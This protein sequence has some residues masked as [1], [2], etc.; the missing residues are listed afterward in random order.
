MDDDQSILKN[1]DERA[2]TSSRFGHYGVDDRTIF[3]RCSVLS[4]LRLR[5]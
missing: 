5:K 1:T 3:S 4:A 2:G